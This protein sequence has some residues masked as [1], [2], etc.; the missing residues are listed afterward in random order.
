MLDAYGAV[1]LQEFF[2]RFYVTI[3]GLLR[4]TYMENPDNMNWILAGFA[5][6]MLLGVLAV[7]VILLMALNRGDFDDRE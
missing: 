1:L 2:K 7:P 5:M 4:Q 3:L 6:A